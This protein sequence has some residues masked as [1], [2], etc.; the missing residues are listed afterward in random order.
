[1]IYSAFTIQHPKGPEGTPLMSVKMPC[2]IYLPVQC[3]CV[4]VLIWVAVTG[5]EVM[6]WG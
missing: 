6:G 4:Y 1:M 2:V 3:F 5:A